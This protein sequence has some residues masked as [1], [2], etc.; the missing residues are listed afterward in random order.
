[1]GCTASINLIFSVIRSSII[2]TRSNVF[3][4]LVKHDTLVDTAESEIVLSSYYDG[5]MISNFSSPQNC[6]SWNGNVLGPQNVTG[7]SKRFLPWWF[8]AT[9]KVAE[10]GFGLFCLI[11]DCKDWSNGGTSAK[12]DCV[13]GA[14]STLVMLGCDGEYIYDNSAVI[15]SALYNGLGGF[16]KCELPDISLNQIRKFTQVLSDA[17]GLSNAFITDKSGVPIKNDVTGWPVHVV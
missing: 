12:I 17:S 14:I 6:R 3:N 7:M 11:S 13:W 8:I 1:M 16:I 15:S 10:A 9:Y 4:E 2:P 5:Y